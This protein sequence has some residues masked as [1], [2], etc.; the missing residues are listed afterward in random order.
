M[1]LV[2]YQLEGSVAM[3]TMDDG[4]ANALSPSMLTALEAALDRAMADRAV[5]LLSGREGRFSAGFDLGVLRAG[6]SEAVAMVRSGFE[7]AA[8]VLSFP[9]PVVIACT[10]HAVAMGAFLLLSGDYRVGAAGP[11]KLTANEVAIGLTMP[12]AAVEICRQRLAPAHFN[13][14]VILAEV[15]APEDAVHAGFLDRVVPNAELQDVTRSTAT[16]MTMLDMAAHAATKLRARDHALR[17]IRAAIEA[18][19]AASQASA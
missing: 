7:L 18:D 2:S 16:G 19:D 11:Y 14:A 5:V 4:K 17:A 8:R 13:R 3:L 6:G 12:H 9:T 15:F 10:G 1:E